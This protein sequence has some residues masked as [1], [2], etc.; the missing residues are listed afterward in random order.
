MKTFVLMGDSITD[1]CRDRNI[2][3]QNYFG[4]GAGMG[5]ANYIMSEIDYKYP[6]KFNV[7]NKGIGGNRIVDLYSRIKQDCINL[8]PD[9]L[10]ILIGVNDVWHEYEYKCGVDIDK[11]YKIYSMY[12]EEIKEACPNI[13]IYI[14]EPFALKGPVPDK[15]EGFLETVKEYAKKAK[16]VA[17]KYDLTFIEMQNKFDALCEKCESTYWLTDGVH[18][19]LGG[20]RMMANEIMKVIE[21]DLK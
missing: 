3:H 19:T 11:Y 1:G 5:Y 18:P 21:K 9:F 10:T 17:E 6:K 7:V 2:G 12:I 14:I 15:F 13:K 8:N 20:Y 16:E 4:L